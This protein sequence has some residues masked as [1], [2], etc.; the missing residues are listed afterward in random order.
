MIADVCGFAGIGPEALIGMP[1]L[2]YYP[3][4]GATL[5]CMDT[6]GPE[7]TTVDFLRNSPAPQPYG[8]GLR[9]HINPARIYVDRYGEA[10]PLLS[11][12]WPLDIPASM[13]AVATVRIIAA[14]TFASL[15]PSSFSAVCRSPTAQQC[16][17]SR[18]SC[19][20]TPRVLNLCF[21]T[22]R[23]SRVA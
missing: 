5:L 13:A 9:Q 10:V 1:T 15:L 6:N 23:Y 4:V 18:S 7:W 12:S 17:P 16:S 8:Y 19:T 20:N 14:S 11:I 3:S 21:P 22:Q 2:S